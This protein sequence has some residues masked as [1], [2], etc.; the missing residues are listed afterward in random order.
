MKVHYLQHVSFENLAYVETW[1]KTK[2]IA[3]SRTAL[4]ENRKL[5]DQNDFECLI[6][7]GGPMGACDEDKFSWMKAEKIFIEQALRNNKIVIG[8]CLGAQMIAD[9]LGA[10]VYKN[11][12][13]EIGWFPVKKTVESGTTIFDSLL[14]DEFYAFHWHGDTFDIPSGAIR[15][16]ESKACKNQGFIYNQKV[17]AFQFHLESTKESIEQLILNCGHELKE[18]GDYIQDAG[19]IRKHFDYILDC[20]RF[21]GVFLES[22]I[23]KENKQTERQ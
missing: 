6:V 14:P 2:K 23:R 3:F 15:F 12:F 13:K 17:F 11:Q 9:V 4:Y 10:K 20:N 19:K 5:P 16:A 22:I 21:M 8:I 1:L 18:S 7:M